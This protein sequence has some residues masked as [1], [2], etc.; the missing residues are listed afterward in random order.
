MN[1]LIFK[2]EKPTALRLASLLSEIDSSINIVG[3]IGSVDDGIKWYHENNM[4]DLVFQDI[5]LSDGNCFDIFDAIEVT[6][7]VIFTTA[8]SQYAIK[9]FQ[10][11]SIDYIIKPY[12]IND[13]RSAL[14][15]RRKLKGT[16]YLPDKKLLEEILKEKSFTPKKRFLIKIGDNYIPINSDDIAYLISDEGLTFATLFNREKHIVNYSIS[17]LSKQMDPASFFQINRKMIV[18]IKSVQKLSSWFNN[19][20][21]TTLD[22]PTNENTVV[23]RAKASSFKEWLDL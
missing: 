13:L 12:D 22:P 14:Q 11:N 1:V 7:P 16:F 21:Q 10:V 23:S 4:P 6:A 3:T 19:R 8:F 18:N 5:V 20:L 17:E 2:D 9:S 15:K